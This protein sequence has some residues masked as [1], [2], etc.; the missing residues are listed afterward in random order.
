[1]RSKIAM[2][3]LFGF[4]ML[5]I[6]LISP[7]FAK[8][9]TWDFTK[10]NTDQPTYRY[11]DK[12][13]T[14]I[15][16]TVYN[17]LTY[18]RTTNGKA[19]LGVWNTSSNYHIDFVFRN[20]SKFEVVVNMPSAVT[21]LL[22]DVDHSKTYTITIKSNGDIIVKN[23]DTTILKDYNIG[24]FKM[25]ALSGSGLQFSFT[26]GYLSVTTNVESSST[27]ETVN[28]WLPTII[29]IAI[30]GICVGSIRKIGS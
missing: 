25:N 3:Y 13:V 28:I 30:M 12:N 5:A 4:L 21:V 18:N 26:G 16:L 6:A 19:V 8:T 1:M 27:I 17:K 15:T 14:S 22:A 2:L 7:A 23:G 24:T 20:D 11:L 10:F 9:Y 29:A